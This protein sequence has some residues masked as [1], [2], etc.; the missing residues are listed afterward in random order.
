MT[1]QQF[2][3]RSC[4]NDFSVLEN[5][6][7][8]TDPPSKCQVMSRHDFQHGKPFQQNGKLPAGSRIQ[9][10]SGF[11]QQYRS[12]R[13]RQH[14]GK[15]G[16]SFFS[17]GKTGYIPPSQ[18]G[19]IHLPQSILHAGMNFRIRQ[20]QIR[21]TER[22]IFLHSLGK[23]L[24][25]GILEYHAD[26]PPDGGQ[27]FL[28]HFHPVHQHTAGMNRDQ[29][30]NTFQQR[31]FPRAVRPQQ[32]HTPAAFRIKYM[33]YAVHRANSAGPFQH[34]LTKFDPH[35]TILKKQNTPNNSTNPAHSFQLPCLPARS[36]A[37]ARNSRHC[38]AA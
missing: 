38:M 7:F 2:G 13:H 6:T 21:G 29:A 3:S 23:K 4:G 31:G 5:Q 20:P 30:G 8:R 37:P 9:H 24:I 35:K 1:F 36:G 15:G 27:I 10:G 12:G 22:N 33:R 28:L 32:S 18:P 17:A 34:Q 25:I 14:A 11:I 16:T 19:Y 26:F